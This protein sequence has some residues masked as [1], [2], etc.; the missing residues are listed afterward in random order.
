MTYPTDPATAATPVSPFHSEVLNKLRTWVLDLFT[1]PPDDT[2]WQ[3]VTFAAGFENYNAT[4]PCEY[5]VRAGVCY[6]RG[7]VKRTAGTLAATTSY[8]V[9]TI[10]V[11]PDQSQWFAVGGNTGY[12]PISAV[13]TTAGQVQLRVGPVAVAYSSIGAV[14]VVG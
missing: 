12:N 10:P 6:L 3:P 7:L 14:F 1:T 2:D 4:Y 11:S 5:R 9:A 13:V 8:E